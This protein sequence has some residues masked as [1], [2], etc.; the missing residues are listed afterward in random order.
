MT[1]AGFF[2]GTSAD[3]DNRFSDK[4]KKLLKQ[5]KFNE[6]L[7]RKV[8]MN[9]INLDVVKPWIAKRITDMLGGIE[10]D[11]V[12]EFVFN[13]LE[14]EKYPDA[15]MMQINLTGFLTGKYAREF[16]AEL[17]A[18]LISAED[19]ADGIPAAILEQKKDEIKKRFEE[20][21]R[22][23][24]SSKKHDEK[25]K[26]R[27]RRSRR[28]SSSSSS[29]SSNHSR[30]KKKSTS[31]KSESSKKVSSDKENSVKSSRRKRSQSKSSSPSRHSKKK[32]RSRSVSRSESFCRPKQRPC[33]TFST[34]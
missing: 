23:S 32:E 3:Q 4:Q 2:R 8:D 22:A 13:Q 27:D 6:I 7:N 16:M 14:A 31:D 11:V 18:L 21:D 5:L 17:W 20:Q 10:D 19:S 15:R 25:S 30:R 34:S 29:S 24:S 9:K 28:S 1:D 33:V 26:K 12:I